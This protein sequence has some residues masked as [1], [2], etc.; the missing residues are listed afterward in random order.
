MMYN[1]IFASKEEELKR[2]ELFAEKIYDV[3]NHNFKYER[4]ET[5]YSKEL[6]AFADVVS[7]L[8]KLLN[9]FQS[10]NNALILDGL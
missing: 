9:A 6:N 4:G 8:K 3:M 2:I 5:L 7:R 10:F 1:K